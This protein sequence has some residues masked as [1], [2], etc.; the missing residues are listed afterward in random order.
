MSSHST[1]IASDCE[2]KNLNIL[3]RN[4]QNEVKSFSPFI[5]EEAGKKEKREYALLKRYLDA[6]RSELF[7][8]SAV[9]LVEGVAEQFIIPEIS[10]KIFGINLVEHNISVIPIHSR[11]FDPFLKMFID[12]NL[13]LTCCAIIDGDA[14]EHKEGDSTTAV[15]NAKGFEVE[16]RI[17][18]FVGTETLETDLF[19]S[20]SINNSYLKDCFK[21]LNHKVS[22][23]NLMA[24]EENWKE[25]LIKRIDGTVKKGRFAQEL[26]LLIDND[27]VVPEYITEALEFVFQTNNINYDPQ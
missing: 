12:G 18:V 9:M 26:S 24:T 11:Y 19:P 6:T 1:H 2:Y 20:K 7:F 17:R 8:S 22:F 21:N 15:E 16:G 14:K 25:E 4:T 13:E 23:S 27:F 5:N 10:K 3:Y